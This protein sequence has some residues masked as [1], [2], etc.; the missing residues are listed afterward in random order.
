MRFLI[1]SV[2]KASVEIQETEKQSAKLEEI[3]EGIVLYFGVAT[4]DLENYEEKIE[5][6]VRK[7]W[8]TK[9]LKWSDDN[10]S[11]NLENLQWWKWGEILIISNFTLYWENN[12]GAKISFT[13]SADFTN[14]ENI[15]NYLVEKLSKKYTTKTWEFWA[16]MKVSAVND[17]PINYV[18]D[19]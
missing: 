5:K 19:Y 15:Y 7:I 1:Q 11:A 18:R 17:W 16:M 10:I 2:S 14:A 13:K 3:G 4:D 12:K 8:I 9:M 6:F